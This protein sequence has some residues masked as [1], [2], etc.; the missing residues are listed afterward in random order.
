M[1]VDRV[2]FKRRRITVDSSATEVGGKLTF[3][4]PKTAASIRTF[5]APE[6]LIDEL[7]RHVEAYPTASG[8]VFSAPDGG[9]LRPGNFRRRVFDPA[10][11]RADL[12]GLHLHDLRHTAASTLAALGASSTEIAAR[13]GH[14]SSATTARVYLHLLGARDERLANLQDEAYAPRHVPT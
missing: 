4:R 5:A 2:D 1:R 8:L 7:R 14:S 9:P 13:L 11:A 3:G 6:F 12:R 10:V